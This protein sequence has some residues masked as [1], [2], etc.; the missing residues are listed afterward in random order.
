MKLSSF[1]EMGIVILCVLDFWWS[2][3]NLR[4]NKLSIEDH[5]YKQMLYTDKKYLFGDHWDRILP[6]C[7]RDRLLAWSH[8]LA[9]HLHISQCFRIDN[10]CSH[11]GPNVILIASCLPYFI[12]SVHN[13]CYPSLPGCPIYIFNFTT[14]LKVSKPQ[15]RCSSCVVLE[16]FF[17]TRTNIFH[18][19]QTW[20]NVKTKFLVRKSLQNFSPHISS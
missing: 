15:D 16:Y 18:I 9:K 10:L 19:P 5:S 20:N 4:A 6:S 11:A 17:W 12:C 1:V 13:N 8:Y 2:L 7:L 3:S 14:Q